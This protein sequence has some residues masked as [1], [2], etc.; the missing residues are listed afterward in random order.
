MLYLDFF[1]CHGAVRVWGARPSAGPEAG[2][3]PALESNFWKFLGNKGTGSF[4]LRLAQNSSTCEPTTLRRKNKGNRT[5]EI[6][7]QAISLL[8]PLRISGL[9]C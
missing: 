3:V 5:H 6:C 8:I 4:W 7:C 9:V 1:G 2:S